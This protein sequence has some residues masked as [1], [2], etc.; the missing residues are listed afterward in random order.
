MQFKIFFDGDKEGRI[1]D[2][3]GIAVCVIGGA[4]SEFVAEDFPLGFSVVPIVNG[5]V[6]AVGNGTFRI[7]FAKFPEPITAAEG[8]QVSI[9][10]AGKRP[11]ICGGRV[12]AVFHFDMEAVS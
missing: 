7:L 11:W 12:D 10:E 2:I 4:T 5:E 9:T 6:V 3:V 1:L 8:F